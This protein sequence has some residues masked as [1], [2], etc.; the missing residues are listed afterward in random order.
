MQNAETVLDVLRE[1]GRR[2]LPLEGLY[3]QLFNPQLYLLA[4]G[5]IYSNKGAMT[6][7]ADA[8][9]ADGMTLGKIERIIDA[10]RHERYRFKP[11]KRVYI[12]KKDGKQQA[13]G[14][15][16]VVGQA[17]RRSRAPA[18]GG[19]LR[20][21]V[22]RA[23]SRLPPRPGLPHRL[24][25]GGGNLDRDQPGLSR[26]TSPSC[27]DRLDLG[28][29]SRRWAR[30]STITGCSGWSARCC[31]PGTWRTG[32]GTPRSAACRRAGLSPRA[33]PTSTW[34]GWTASSRRF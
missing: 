3:R 34:T 6:P 11:V 9:T 21:A 26:A 30:R 17:A 22:L 14:S 27:F 10:V 32:Y 31:K 8:E 2:G 19:V 18:V 29:C 1:R 33:C 4:Y 24:A 13:A 20:A 15:A 12:P 7:G 23:L 28:S 16:V 25:R 5:R